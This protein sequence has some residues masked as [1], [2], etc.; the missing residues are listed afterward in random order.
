M[1]EQRLIGLLDPEAYEPRP[2]A[3][4]LRETHI[5]WVLLAGDTAYKVK[6]P[7]TLPFL[8]YGSLERRRVLCRLEMRL[9]ARLAPRI[10]RGVRAIVPRDGGLRIADE[11][12]PEAIEYAVE[13]V[14]YDER[15]TLA[16]RTAD[17]DVLRAVGRRIARFHAAAA[18]P[19]APARS[20]AALDTMLRENFTTLR[21]LGVDVSDAIAL[22]D[23]ALAGRRAELLA[24]AREGFVRDG[25]GDL[26]AEHVLL[27]Q[28]IEI[29]DCVEF[30]P[31]L[32]RIDTGLDLAFLV[33][34]VMCRGRDLAAALVDGYRGAGGDP[35]DDVLLTFFAAQR[36]LI[37]AKI[38]LIRAR[39]VDGADA[40]RRRADAAALLALAG[41]LAWEVRLGRIAA[42]CGPA[43][44]GKS[45]LANALAARSGARVLSSDVVRKHLLGIPPTTRAPLPAYDDATN[46]RTY[47]AL[48]HQAAAHLAAGE[49]VLVDATFRFAA[50]RETFTEAVGAV[51]PLWIE[52]RVPADIAAQ[53]A[54]ARAQGVRTSD[55]GAD[56]AARS[57]S[58][59]TP[60]GGIAVDT[61]GDIAATVAA[62]RRL[63]DT[64]L[65]GGDVDELVLERVPDQLGA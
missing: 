59:F 20:V 49:A 16:N 6:K 55:A 29:V 43:A 62:L 48:G 65:S 8:D 38:A 61:T 4:E 11:A 2:A 42:I 21:R 63:L 44:S 30:D 53:R 36:A 35:G 1:L 26:R 39:Q 22:A 32:R 17:A 10:Y 64:R 57:V 28:G 12:D 31:A 45:T 25:H 5:S 47:A 14:R 51:E 19:G 40:V 54:A 37:R 41:R 18:V 3:V 9:N 60:I 24:R 33:M 23:A 34:D 58:E 7:L 56:V 27:E 13:M 46:R 15:A 50:D 52:C